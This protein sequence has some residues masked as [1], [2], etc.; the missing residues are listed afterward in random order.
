LTVIVIV[1]VGAI[2]LLRARPQRRE[3]FT[4]EDPPS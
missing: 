4:E 3:T 2:A 1:F